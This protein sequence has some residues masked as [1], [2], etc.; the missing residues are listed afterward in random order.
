[1]KVVLAGGSGF[2]GGLLVREFGG[3]GYEVV[4][5]SREDGPVQG[6]RVA[7]WDGETVGEWARELDGADAV[8]NL[9]GAPI[10]LKLTEE[11][12]R[13]IVDSRVHSTDAIGKAIVKSER[14]PPVWVNASAIGYYGDTGDRRT[15]EADP[16]QGDSF[17][18]TS[19]AEWERATERYE[20]PGTRKVRLRS[21]IVLGREG[22]M[23]PILERLTKAFLGGRAGPG[24]QYIPW[25]HGA[26]AAAMYRW[27]VE[28]DVEGPVNG[29]APEPATNA[30]FMAALREVLRRPP[31]P[32]APVF[33]IKIVGKLFG[34]D[35]EAVLMS[36]RVVPAVALERGFTFRYPDLREALKDLYA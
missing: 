27:A 14:P 22:G 16:P 35:P 19:V 29:T 20:T 31:A 12:K 3:A 11:N 2:V 21:G 26:D 4:V 1:L 33:G 9:S 6:A 8:V 28:T 7:L 17:F 24:D 23:L 36:S 15:T 25:I 34:P 13:R 10:T 5:L 32:P 30:E 18:S